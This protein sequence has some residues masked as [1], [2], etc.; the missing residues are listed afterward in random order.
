[1]SSKVNNDF[2]SVKELALSFF[3]SDTCL[4]N[5]NGHYLIA[6]GYQIH[7]L[8]CFF[9]TNLE[10]KGKKVEMCLCV[11][12]VKK[13]RNLFKT[14]HDYLLKSYATMKILVI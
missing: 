4:Q 8:F 13:T 7:C 2:N 12:A 1:M 6:I 3:I 5:V 10:E 9:N 14:L 11:T